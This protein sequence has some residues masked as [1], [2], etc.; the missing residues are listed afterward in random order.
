MEQYDTFSRMRHFFTNVR[1][2]SEI[3]G[4]ASFIASKRWKKNR[5]TIHPAA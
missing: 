4:I 3:L 2:I 1:R 5:P